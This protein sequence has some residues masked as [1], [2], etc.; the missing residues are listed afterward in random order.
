MPH[1]EFQNVLAWTALNLGGDIYD[2][3]DERCISCGASVATNEW[4]P[5]PCD[6]DLRDSNNRVEPEIALTRK[7]VERVAEV[8]CGIGFAMG[9]GVAFDYPYGRERW[10]TLQFKLIRPIRWLGGLPRRVKRRFNPPP[11]RKTYTLDELFAEVEKDKDDAE[12]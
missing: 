1:A 5:S 3:L 10:I 6:T 9:D 8:I 2:K 4:C 11:P 7:E 12:V